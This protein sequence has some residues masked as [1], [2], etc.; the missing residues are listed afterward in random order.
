MTPNHESALYRESGTDE[1]M[2]LVGDAGLEAW[3]SGA[4]GDERF[5]ANL[6]RVWAG[7]PADQRGRSLYAGIQDNRATI[8]WG[9]VVSALRGIRADTIGDE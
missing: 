3:L 8:G 4:L 1:A 5:A 7:L 9:T 6:A 2:R